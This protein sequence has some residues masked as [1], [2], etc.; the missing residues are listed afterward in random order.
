MGQRSCYLALEGVP[1]LTYLILFIVVDNLSNQPSPIKMHW[2]ISP[3]IL[4]ASRLEKAALKKNESY[5]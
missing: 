1:K 5:Y 3:V 2:L 4:E